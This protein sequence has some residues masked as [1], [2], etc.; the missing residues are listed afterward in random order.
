M[1]FSPYQWYPTQVNQSSRRTTSIDDSQIQ[2]ITDEKYSFLIDELTDISVIKLVGVTMRYFSSR[3]LRKIMSTFLGIVKLQNGT[4]Q[5]IVNA[6]KKLLCDVQ[7]NP[8]NRVCELV[9]K[10]LELP[11]LLMVRCVTH[12][13]WLCLMLLQKHCLKIS[14]FLVQD[15]YSWL[16][17]SSK[18]QPM[19]K[20]LFETLNDGKEPLQIYKVC[21]AVPD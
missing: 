6:I 5:S 16:S 20:T 14:I 15:T 9:K 18:W 13:N 1:N 8:Q 19:Y 12:F 2:D 7:V 11:N 4:A 17:H 10:E 3:N 21:G